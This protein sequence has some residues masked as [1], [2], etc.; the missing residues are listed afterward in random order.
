VFR[1]KEVNA[2]P[3]LGLMV[4][5][6]ACLGMLCCGSAWALGTPAGTVIANT[7]T[8][9]YALDGDPTVR[10]ISASHSFSILEVI[11]GVVAWQDAA[12]VQVGSPQADS[13]LTFLLTNTGN[14][15]E[16]FALTSTDTLPGDDFDPAAQ[17]VWL[18][19]NGIAGLQTGGATPDTHYQAG[20]ND[21]DLPADHSV[22][23]Y[24]L[25]NIP[26]G[27]SDGATGRARLN[28]AATT[29]GAAN[30]PAGTALPGAGLNGVDAVVGTSQAQGGAV[31]SYAVASVGV[32][33]TK[34]IHRIVDRFGGSQ[35]YPGAQ[36]TYR[37]LVQVSGGGAAEGLVISDPIPAGM[38][39][40]PG[41]IV[42]D[43]AAQTDASDAP[44]DHSD[45]NVTNPGTV[46]VNLG[47]A[48]APATHA[49]DFTTTIN[50]N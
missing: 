7:A 2:P 1:L 3:V 32:S 14:G 18:E 37:I 24:L 21:P 28:A 19:T 31:G 4:V 34:S 39:Y 8:V 12:P 6:A 15:P 29:P 26:S 23:I 5:L 40:L 49:I 11:D 45:F 9:T 20:L 10:T 42:L 17:S 46:T 27:L 36:V 22:K 35:P 44:V 43:G 25:S 13:A 47:D 30:A 48:A 41:S 50:I 16:A 38:T 33:L